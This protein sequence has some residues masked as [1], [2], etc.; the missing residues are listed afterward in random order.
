MMTRYHAGSYFATIAAI[1]NT[2]LLRQKIIKNSIFLTKSNN[3]RFVKPMCF[4]IGSFYFFGL[5]CLWHIPSFFAEVAVRVYVATEDTVSNILLKKYLEEIL[6]ENVK[7]GNVL[8]K[9]GVRL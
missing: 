1:Y 7:L 5:Y 4:V 8:E 2:F 3:P 9:D 6:C